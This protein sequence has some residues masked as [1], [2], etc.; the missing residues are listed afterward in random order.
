MFRDDKSDRFC[1]YTVLNLSVSWVNFHSSKTYCT[2]YRLNIAKCIAR[3]SF[4]NIT[5]CLPIASMLLDSRKLCKGHIWN[6][7]FYKQAWKLGQTEGEMRQ[8]EIAYLSLLSNVFVVLLPWRFRSNSHTADLE[9][10]LPLHA[11]NHEIQPNQRKRQVSELKRQ[12]IGLVLETRPYLSV[13]R[14]VNMFWSI[15]S[16]G[17]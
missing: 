5:K 4:L 12:C 2:C 8:K 9:I 17:S 3:V 14:M 15:I 11:H 13:W 16:S 10:Q 1:V 7:G 6:M